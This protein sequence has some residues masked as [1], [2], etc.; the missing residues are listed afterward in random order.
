[1]LATKNYNNFPNSA[2]VFHTL[3]KLAKTIPVSKLKKR[4]KISKRQ[5][6]FSIKSFFFFFD[7]ELKFQK[8]AKLNQ[9]NQIGTATKI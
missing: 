7:V 4:V 5:K 1:M 2:P 9:L 6:I 8:L 3:H